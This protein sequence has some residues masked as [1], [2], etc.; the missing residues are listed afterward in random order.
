MTDD[1]LKV[2][3]PMIHLSQTLHGKLHGQIVAKGAEPVDVLIGAVYASMSLA[4]T[5]TG[6]PAGALAWMQ[7]ALDSM[8]RRILDEIADGTRGAD[9]YP[10]AG[11]PN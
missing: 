9:G 8:E 1:E 2:E 3:H 10:I 5:I 6:G 11:S 4:S 7:N